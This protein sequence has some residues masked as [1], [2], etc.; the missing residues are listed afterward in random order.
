MVTLRYPYSRD[1]PEP[2]LYMRVTHHAIDTGKDVPTPWSVVS[3][4]WILEKFT[5]L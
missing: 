3:Q 5:F 1:V 4:E 2:H